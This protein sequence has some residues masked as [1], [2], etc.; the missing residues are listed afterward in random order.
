[1]SKKGHPALT[2][3]KSR[4]EGQDFIEAHCFPVRACDWLNM[5]SPLCHDDRL[6]KPGNAG[7]RLVCVTEH[8]SR[9]YATFYKLKLGDLTAANGSTILTAADNGGR[10]FA[11]S[12]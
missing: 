7:I 4:V 11:L 3:G 1:M 12:I 10:Y 9:D 2:N 8:E 5:V 6:I